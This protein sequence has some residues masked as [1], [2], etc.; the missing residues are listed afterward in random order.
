MTFAQRRYV[1]QL[2]DL[3]RRTPGT[4]GHVRPADR[5]LAA[6]LASRGIPLGTVRDALL[7][8]VA[9]RTLRPDQAPPLPPI[10]SL[11]YILPILDE[12]LADPPDPGYLHY[13]HYRLASLAPA[14]VLP[15]DHQFP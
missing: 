10:R 13:L 6:C 14:L 4:T 15:I 11:H 5:S 7:L 3:Y 1:D 2:L 9:R 12:L 8:A